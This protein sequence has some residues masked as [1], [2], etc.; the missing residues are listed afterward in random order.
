LE[1]SFD[2]RLQAAKLDAMKEF[3]Y[4]A[5][6]E[7]NNPLANIATRAQTLLADETDPERRRRLAAINTQA[8]RAHEMLADM[9]LFARPPKPSLQPVD[10]VRLID[11]VVATMADDAAGQET[12]IHL[13]SRRDTLTIQADPVQLRAA[14][15]AVCRNSLEA[16]GHGGNLSIELCVSD[17]DQPPYEAI[18]PRPD[19]A[20]APK[21]TA[22]DRTQ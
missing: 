10:V 6:H 19:G 1:T 17:T 3:A 12:A 22:P 20:M 16:L 11:D 5:G 8:F 13:P 7:L 4:G 15:L 9:M 2:E 21:Q 14:L 18:D